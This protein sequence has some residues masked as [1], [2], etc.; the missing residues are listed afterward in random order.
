MISQMH[1]MFIITELDVC[2]QVSQTIRPTMI[3]AGPLQSA[4]IIIWLYIQTCIIWLGAMLRPHRHMCAH[5]HSHCCYALAT[6]EVFIEI[7]C[8]IHSGRT[9]S[10]FCLCA[11][12]GVRVPSAR[13]RGFVGD[14]FVPPRTEKCIFFCWSSHL[15]RALFTRY[16]S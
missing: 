4:C 9:C 8:R 12:S 3:T 15:T 7:M 11:I 5:I 14:V 10:N 6:N 2:L 1:R 13:E 16:G